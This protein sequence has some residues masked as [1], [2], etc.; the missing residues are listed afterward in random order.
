MNVF[1]SDIVSLHGVV[2]SMIG[3]RPEN[4]DD[5]DFLDTPIGF[6]CI[7]CD[8]MGGGPGGK[9]ASYIAKHEIHMSLLQCNS[10]SPRENAL[11]MA[12]AKANEA[13]ETKMQEVPSLIGMGTTVVAIL[14]NQESAI[15]AHAGD[16]RCYQIRNKKCI[17]RSQDHSLVAQLVEK[18]V[19]TEEEARIS[20]QSNVITRG[21]GSISNHVP[22][23]DVLNYKK[24]D[25]FVICTDGVWGVMPQ[26][27][28]LQHFQ[29][30]TSIQDIVTCLSQ[31]VDQIGYS[32][33]GGH[34]NHTVAVI[35]M[36]LN[37]LYKSSRGKRT[38]LYISLL[39]FLAVVAL[40]LIVYIF[41]TKDRTAQDELTDNSTYSP[42]SA[43]DTHE[44]VNQGN[45]KAGNSGILADD[46]TLLDS[47]R[48]SILRAKGIDTPKDS[49][50]TKTGSSANTVQK[51]N[52]TKEAKEA[53][54]VTQ[55]IINN[56]N[57]A[58]NIAEETSDIAQNKAYEIQKKV[59]NLLKNLHKL[60][61]GKDLQQDVDSVKANASLEK[62]WW[63]L[64]ARDKDRKYRLMP[65]NIKNAK[66]QIEIL[67]SIKG[68]L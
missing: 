7:V 31:E 39:S 21:L 10:S 60:T 63:A 57:A 6:L 40:A 66:K 29:Q 5:F 46:T 68:Q 23:I 41:T 38:V 47:I 55:Q 50:S 52:T 61:N 45:D 32:K 4:Q 20:P 56:Y 36:E 12:F 44:S 24:G 22:D 9:T 28:F 30:G 11:K 53:R 27:E 65:S 26:K 59:V 16:S 8:G 2:N 34:D 49:D 58:I 35:E 17:Y 33:G 18:K 25:K 67:D 19:L 64:K 1:R 13:I 42:S 43:N 62:N 37:S 14:I 48:K 3:G 54:V 15:V 51:A